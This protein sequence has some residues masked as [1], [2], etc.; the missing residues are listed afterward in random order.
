MTAHLKNRMTTAESFRRLS[1][2]QE[3][4]FSSACEASFYDCGLSRGKHISENV[5]GKNMNF[6]PKRR[7]HK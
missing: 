3:Q 7:I 1:L 6:H 4:M 2:T 5:T